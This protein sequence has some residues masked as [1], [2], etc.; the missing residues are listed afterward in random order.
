MEPVDAE[1]CSADDGDSDGD[2]VR[3]ADDACPGTPP[4][5][6]VDAQGCAESQR[7]A[8]GD[9]VS[10]AADQCPDTQ[11]GTAVDLSRRR[12]WRKKKS[13]QTK[14][15]LHRVVFIETAGET[16]AKVPSNASMASYR[17]TRTVTYDDIPEGVGLRPRFRPCCCRRS[18][19]SVPQRGPRQS[20]SYDH[21]RTRDGLDPEQVARLPALLPPGPGSSGARRHG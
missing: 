10:D 21:G 6:A 7:D 20:C 12:D 9:G 2:R 8:D 1:G 3:N 13:A 11:A 4:G 19:G 14:K 17:V 15:G 16:G 18:L 5:A